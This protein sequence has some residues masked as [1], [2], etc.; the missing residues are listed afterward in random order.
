MYFKLDDD[1]G[2]WEG[3][4]ARLKNGMKNMKNS[5]K[6]HWALLISEAEKLQGVSA[7]RYWKSDEYQD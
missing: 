6:Y 4:G 7:L 3:R 1:N 5:Y 2:S